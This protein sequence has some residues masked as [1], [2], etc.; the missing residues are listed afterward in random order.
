MPDTKAKQSESWIPLIILFVVLA[1]LYLLWDILLV[2]ILAGLFAFFISPLVRFFD[3]R[4]PH[5]FSIISVYLLIGIVLILLIGLLVPV[6]SNQAQQLVS[7]TPEY[8]DKARDISQRIQTRYL[9]LP[10]RWRD[11][12]D[13][14]LSQLQETLINLT[15][16]T[17]PAVIAF[18]SNLFTII[19]IPLLAFFMLMQSSD[20]KRML[21]AITPEN[22]RA[23]IEDL[24]GCA[25]RALWNFFKGQGLLMLTVGLADGIGLFLVGMPYAIIFGIIG[26]LLELI[27]SFGPAFTTILVGLVGLL[28]D[29]VLGLKAIGVTIAVQLLENSFLAPVVMGKA[30]GLSPLTVVFAIFIGGTLTGVIGA[31]LAIP[32]AMIIKI[33]ILYFY[34]DENEL[35]D[36]QGICH[37]SHER[38]KP[39]RRRRRA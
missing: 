22:R 18:F 7:A 9:G 38:E 35:P 30:V 21:I 3:R 32:L 14:A 29:P 10:D 33:Y 19:L 26:G 20:Y 34:A 6:V 28:I 25:S 36:G 4:F 37:H 1:I 11:I 31:I 15:R 16:R 13:S 24:T 23:T 17:I 39:A 12:G 2:F 5:I 8:L 27:P